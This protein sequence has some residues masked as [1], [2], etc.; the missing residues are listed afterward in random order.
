LATAPAPKAASV[1]PKPAVHAGSPTAVWLWLL[2]ALTAALFA[3][4]ALRF[5]LI[6]RRPEFTDSAGA[7]RSV[8]ELSPAEA[9]RA[10]TDY[11]QQRQAPVQAE[12]SQVEE[13]RALFVVGHYADAQRLLDTILGQNPRSHEAW[14]L[15]VRVLCAQG[16][17]AGLA[18]RM[19]LISELTGETGELWDRVL[20]LR[21][22]LDP[23]NP[24][25]QPSQPATHPAQPQQPPAATVS[26]PASVQQAPATSASSAV[27]DA[28]R[29]AT[30]YGAHP[31]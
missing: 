16:D 7:A 26:R 3:V 15:L 20:M 2:S 9:E 25:Y 23:G 31:V 10:Y 14:F 12:T 18:Q 1:A 30:A 19:P 13:A 24:P 17:S 6:R 11:M 4:W 28:L 22:E 5:W 21:H 8:F 29:M 27:D